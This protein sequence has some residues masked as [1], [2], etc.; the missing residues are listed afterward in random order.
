MGKG[1][2]GID[3]KN[4]EDSY[5]SARQLDY[6]RQLLLKRRCEIVNGVR[7]TG[8][9][10]MEREIQVPDPIDQGI[11][12]TERAFDYETSRRHLLTLRQIDQALERIDEGSYGYCEESGEEIGIRRL[13]AQPMATL[14]IESQERLE[15]LERLRRANRII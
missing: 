1:T 9:R 15:Q 7:E 2:A 5:M 4:D 10:L 13:Q 3:R 6:F 12:E 11:A 8:V 14:S